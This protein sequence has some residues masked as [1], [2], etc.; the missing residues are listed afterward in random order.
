M[1][2]DLCAGIVPGFDKSRLSPELM[3]CCG[4][5][6]VFVGEIAALNC[7]A[8]EMLSVGESGCCSVQGACHVM[9]P[10]IS[11]K[12]HWTRWSDVPNPPQTPAQNASTIFVPPLLASS[13]RSVLSL[14]SGI[15]RTHRSWVVGFM[16]GLY[17][18]KNADWKTGSVAGLKSTKVQ[19]LDQTKKAA[20]VAVADTVAP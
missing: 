2:C 9:Y 17:F 4:A 15:L 13:T 10:G 6:L 5:V 18:L 20:M 14:K 19:C 12:E 8:Y 3:R 7:V 11:G 16:L 1:I